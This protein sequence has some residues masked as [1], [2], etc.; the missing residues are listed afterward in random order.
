MADTELNLETLTEASHSSAEEED[1]K[2]QKIN[3]LLK[4]IE[5]Q[6][7]LFVHFVKY[8]YVLAKSLLGLLLLGR[9]T[10]I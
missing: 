1:A 8:I 2:M 3:N 5:A 7:F 10:Q 4:M 6:V 9:D